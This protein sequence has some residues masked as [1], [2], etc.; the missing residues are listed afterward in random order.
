VFGER[1]CEE[2]CQL[3]DC[4]ADGITPS[5]PSPAAHTKKLKRK[6]LF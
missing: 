6:K 4:D 2:V 1:V 3:L 5:Y